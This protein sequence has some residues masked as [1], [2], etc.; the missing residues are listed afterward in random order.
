MNKSLT[1]SSD[2]SESLSHKVPDQ[3]ALRLLSGPQVTLTSNG[4]KIKTKMR[5]KSLRSI[6][7]NDFTSKFEP[8]TITQICSF[9]ENITYEFVHV[10][11]GLRRYSQDQVVAS[12]NMGGV[13]GKV[14]SYQTYH[15]LM[16]E[17]SIHFDSNDC[18]IGTMSVGELLKR[19]ADLVCDQLKPHEQSI[20]LEWI[21]MKLDLSSIL[22]QKIGDSNKKGISTGQRRRV[23]LAL[24]LLH[25]PRVLFLTNV[26]VGLDNITAHR[27]V[28]LL[29]DDLADVAKC[30]IILVGS[31]VPP[32]NWQF[33]DNIHLMCSKGTLCCGDKMNMAKILFNSTS[34]V[35]SDVI[36]KIPGHQHTMNLLLNENGSKLNGF[37][38]QSI[39][40]I[41]NIFTMVP[42]YLELHLDNL[43][44]CVKN[45]NSEIERYSSASNPLD[46][47]LTV[48]LTRRGLGAMM[49]R[50]EEIVTQCSRCSDEAQESLML[51]PKCWWSTYHWSSSSVFAQLRSCFTHCTI[52]KLK[53][54]KSYIA[55]FLCYLILGSVLGYVFFDIPERIYDNPAMSA[56]DNFYQVIVPSIDQWMETDEGRAI[57]SYATDSLRLLQY[58][59]GGS[60]E[61]PGPHPLVKMMVNGVDGSGR[62]PIRDLLSDEMTF[63]NTRCFIRCLYVKFPFNR[64]QYQYPS[65][66]MLN[67]PLPNTISRFQDYTCLDSPGDLSISDILGPDET[68]SDVVALLQ[69]AHFLAT[70]VDYQIV[71]PGLKEAI[72]ADT[73]GLNYWLEVVMKS[74]G[75]VNNIVD[76]MGLPALPCV[77]LCNPWPDAFDPCYPESEDCDSPVWPEGMKS[78]DEL[79]NGLS[80]FSM[81]EDDLSYN[82]SIFN[83]VLQPAT[84]V[85]LS[86]RR[87]A[88]FHWTDRY[89][90]WLMKLFP[91]DWPASKLFGSVAHPSSYQSGSLDMET[92]S[93]MMHSVESA[94][95]VINDDCNASWCLNFA[96]TVS[97]VEETVWN[98]LDILWQILNTTGCVFAINAGIPF[99][100][101]EGLLTWNTQYR[102]FIAD[103]KHRVY[104]T[105]VF[106]IAQLLSDL[107]YSMVP[108][109]ACAIIWTAMSGFFFTVGIALRTLLMFVVMAF[110][111]YSFCYMIGCMIE[112]TEVSLVVCAFGFIIML[113]YSGFILRDT[114]DTFKLMDILQVFALHRWSYFGLMLNFFP[115]E[116]ASSWAS[117]PGERRYGLMPYDLLLWLSGVPADC[118]PVTF[119]LCIGWLFTL[120]VTFRVISVLVLSWKRYQ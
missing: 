91:V 119:E 24:L 3:Y 109:I 100:T 40:N 26:L 36:K 37:S 17:L 44:T 20:L 48:E 84:S 88:A 10:M 47:L 75:L 99:F 103:S 90:T 50:A 62:T 60:A 63:L 112:R 82:L 9:N 80:M 53:P 102:R 30:T 114:S 71:F 18:L 69:V 4:L 101:M 96:S 64:S 77:G 15:K 97:D 66:D 116:C 2:E 94:V 28:S 89:D 58:G 45:L 22:G 115:P 42:E 32:I 54:L 11:R 57:A 105:T 38:Q 1:D 19:R 108:L 118:S 8:G 110:S 52:L 14:D 49:H 61:A 67:E 35:F 92:W 5:D 65:A 55:S 113:L 23:S 86:E 16:P 104:G 111:Y 21:V 29:R 13:V 33:I 79:F 41:C 7:T 76:C 25:R 81:S 95:N 46:V 98:L 117:D 85:N 70:Q 6:P 12:I 59:V 56:V 72:E 39:R 78:G 106:S 51:C 120:G 74:E 43:D 87:P 68:I 83:K 93:V 107:I 27:V 31:D 34:H 73:K